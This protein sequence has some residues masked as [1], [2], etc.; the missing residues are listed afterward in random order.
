MNYRDHFKNKVIYLNCDDPEESNF[1]KIFAQLFNEFELMGLIS[2]HYDT[3]GPTYMLELTRDTI[4]AYLNENGTVN[5]EALIRHPLEGNGDFRNAECVELLRRSDI[6]VTNP[7][8]SLFREYVAQLMEY[9]KK[10]LIIGNMNAI[11]YKEI[12]PLIKNNQL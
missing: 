9:E 10:F 11:T 6:V 4:G 12:F 7:P 1:W 5:H 2:T 8:F 3:V